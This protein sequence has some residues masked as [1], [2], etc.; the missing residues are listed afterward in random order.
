MIPEKERDEALAYYTVDGV[1]NYKARWRDARRWRE[2][3]MTYSAIGK[4]LGVTGA[5]AKSME[6]QAKAESYR[7]R[8]RL[9]EEA[10]SF[11]EHLRDIWPRKNAYKNRKSS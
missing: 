2:A 5:R 3:G 9:K 7:T 4:R 1:V 8:N 10:R 11:S 6:A